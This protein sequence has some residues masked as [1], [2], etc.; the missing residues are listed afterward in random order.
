MFEHNSLHL[1]LLDLSCLFKAALN[2][3]VELCVF[4]KCVHI[5]IP[6]EHVT[7]HT[8]ETLRMILLLPGNLFNQGDSLMKH[9]ATVAA[10]KRGCLSLSSHSCPEAFVLSGCARGYPVD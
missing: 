4:N 8:G 7:S 5:S 10:S 1:Y 6:N 9:T 2:L 3:P